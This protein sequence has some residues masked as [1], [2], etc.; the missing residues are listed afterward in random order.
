[1]TKVLRVFDHTK[2]LKFDYVSEQTN[3]VR[4]GD[5]VYKYSPASQAIHDAEAYPATNEIG[6][7]IQTFDDGE[8]RTDMWGMTC[9]SECSFA[10]RLLV[11]AYRPELL[12]D[13][14]K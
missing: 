2:F 1:M 3:I 11:K 12:P 10:T 14:L 8:F 7:V 6:V 13:L 5:I 9:L 4:L